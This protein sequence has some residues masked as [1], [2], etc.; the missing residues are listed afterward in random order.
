ILID[1]SDDVAVALVEILVDGRNAGNDSS[2]PYSI[3]W[4][5]RTVADGPHALHATARDAAGNLGKSA[6]VPVLVSNAPGDRIPP[7]VTIV[8][9]AGGSILNGT[10]VVE[11][12][13]RDDTG[14]AKVE[15]LLDGALLGEDATAP[16]SVQWDTR[17]ARDGDHTLLARA[18]DAAKN[19]GTSPAV[20]VRVDNP[21]APAGKSLVGYWENWDGK[22]IPLNDVDDRYNV[23]NIAFPYID[24]DGTV[25]MVDKNPTPE[26]IA[27]AQARGKKV[28]LSL[29]G[30]NGAAHLGTQQQE[31]NFVTSLVVIIRQYG[32]DGIDIDLEHG[33]VVEGPPD[34]PTGP[35]ARLISSLKRLLAEFGDDLLLTFAPETANLVGGIDAY[36]TVWGSYLPV[37][38]ALRDSVD[39]VHMQYYNTGPMKGLN[40]KVY[41]PGTQDFVVALT[42]AVIEGF[43]I[44]TT[45]KRYP[46]LRPEQVAV[47]LPATAQAGNNFVPLDVAKAALRCLKTGDCGSGYKPAKIYPGLRGAMTWDVNWDKTSGYRFAD[48]VFECAVKDNC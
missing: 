16:Y 5:T 24:P 34:A 30:Q 3:A 48:A 23:L 11:A 14:V 9:P 18:H 6:Q 19:N 7:T 37:F 27:Q 41:Q 45:G 38:I 31:D 43:D 13:A 8:R 10:V 36:G 32:L 12:D 2:A 1:A 22:W 35:V 15:F 26:E 46:G 40:D 44:A 33:L 20:G 47:G 17:T 4:D 28:L 21:T 39:W 29:G 25:K 42:E